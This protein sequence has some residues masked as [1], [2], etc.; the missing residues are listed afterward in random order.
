MGKR[1]TL[2]ET[3]NIAAAGDCIKLNEVASLH[4]AFAHLPLPTKDLY[5]KPGAIANLLS[6]ARLADEYYMICNTRVDD[7]I[8]VQSRDDGKY[9]RFQ[10]C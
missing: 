2:N 9:L 1:N 6:F 3:I 8:Y 10:R 5:Y 4:K 7:A